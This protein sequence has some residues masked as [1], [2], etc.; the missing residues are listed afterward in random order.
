V[1]LLSKD[2]ITIELSRIDSK[3]RGIAG[4]KAASLCELISAGYNVPEG[5]VVT[6][7]AYERFVADNDLGTLSQERLRGLDHEDSKEIET[8]S[9]ELRLVV[10]KAN[11]P[12]HLKEA[13]IDSYAV[14]G[15]GRVAVR[16]SAT[17]EDLPDASFAGQYDTSLNIEGDEAVID[18]IRKCFAS[19]WTSRAIAYREENNI[20][21]D[22]V[23]VAVIVQ[24][25]VDA[26]SAGVMFTRNPLSEN[27]SEMMIESNFGLGESVVGG[28]AVPD[29]YVV[30]SKDFS[31]VSKEIGTKDKIVNIKAGGGVALTSVSGEAGQSSSL[32]DTEVAKLVQV[33][34]SI[35]EHFGVPQDVEWA[36]DQKGELHILQSRPITVSAAHRSEA[37]QVFWTRGYSDDYWNDNVTPLFFDLLGDHLTYIVND[38]TNAI[39]GYKDMP[40]QLMKLFRAHAYFNLEVLRTKVINEM[41]PF[42]RSEDLMNYF[43]EG[44]GPYGK[45]TMRSL[46]FNL[47]AR[48]MAEIRVMLLDPDGSMT[49]TAQAYSTFTDDVF[50][51]YCAE[52]DEHLGKLTEGGTPEQLMSLAD[53]LDKVMM[54]HFRLV[55]Y[56][57]PVHNIGMN[58]I[59]NYLLKRWLGEKAQVA[60]FPVLVA[61]LEH[62]TS[63]TNRRIYALADTI[64][65][66]AE[67]L[68]IVSNTPSGNLAQSL[69]ESD[70][71]KGFM[72][73]F[74]AF[75]RDFGVRGFTREMYYPRWAEEPSYVFDILKSLVS[76]KGRD[77]EAQETALRRK[78]ARAEKVVNR[79]IRNQRFGRL[80]ILLF[81]TILGMSRTYIAFRENQRF[82]LDRWITRHRRIFL[83]LGDC[84]HREGY[85]DRPEDIFFLER[86][87]IRSIVRGKPSMSPQEIANRAERRHQEFRL[88]EDV[89]PPKFLQGNREFNDPLPD[90]SLALKG[91]PASQGVITGIVRV[92]SSIDDIP[93]VRAGEILVVQRT[94]PGWTPVFSKIGG[95]VTETGGILSHGA[96]V[97][98]EFG[99]PAVTNIR[100]ACHTL[101]T[102]QVVTLD[103]NQGLVVLHDSE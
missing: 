23:R 75:L 22:Q 98:R 56:G 60:L 49:K 10:E 41:P 43:P 16:S 51:P 80:K 58:L 15:R 103:G 3:T 30:N 17:A 28:Y 83:S 31:L 54:K 26:K 91:I 90:T 57:I 77:L 9:A 62:K 27:E 63:E 71:S 14:L 8:K 84:L 7:D 70:M 42:L 87:E 18:H 79:A 102:G 36:Y 69:D 73:K 72:E 68:R 97:S 47:R 85:L 29:R 4:G 95:L 100:N 82:N 92:L 81:N 21:H 24:K 96:V 64:R 67:L 1:V 48:L 38:E 61:G 33:G 45:D 55:R 12:G 5:F 99:I 44:K 74:N 35:E 11:L 93:Q 66:N 76:D 2:P 65:E 52:F 86:R 6:T 37:D 50:V 32:S 46:P 59:T 40:T 101:T 94:D 39:M 78:R 20:P 34:T 89:T 53:D 19:I 88:H 13:F 25:M